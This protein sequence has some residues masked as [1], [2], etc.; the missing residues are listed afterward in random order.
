MSKKYLCEV[1]QKKFFHC[2][3]TADTPYEARARAV[4]YSEPDDGVFVDAVNIQEKD[5]KHVIYDPY[6]LS[7]LLWGHRSLF[8]EKDINAMKDSDN[9]HN[10]LM[11]ASDLLRNYNHMK[12]D[13][14]NMERTVMDAVTNCPDHYN[15][16]QVF[17][18]VSDAMDKV[19]KSNYLGENGF[20]SSKERMARLKNG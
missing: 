14:E 10:V 12:K 17:F 16:T 6:E 5:P 15:A 3:I 11:V 2:E 7:R 1:V 20:V 19:K 18:A 4:E 8:D 13:W 9:V